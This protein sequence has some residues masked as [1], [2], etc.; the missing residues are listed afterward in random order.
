MQLQLVHPDGVIPPH[1]NGTEI[2]VAAL[3]QR[4]LLLPLLSALRQLLS[5]PRHPHGLGGHAPLE[6]GSP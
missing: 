4:L 5:A 2:A 3:V 1:L 6:L